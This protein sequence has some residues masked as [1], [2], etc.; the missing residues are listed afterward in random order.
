MSEKTSLPVLAADRVTVGHG[1]G[2]RARASSRRPLAD[3][4]SLPAEESG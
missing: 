2:H 3:A 4:P 1:H